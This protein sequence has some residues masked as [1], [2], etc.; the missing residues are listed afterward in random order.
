M[1]DRLLYAVPTAR[2]PRMGFVLSMRGLELGCKT[3]ERS[4][5]DFAYTVGPVQMARSIA[6]GR[7]IDEGYDYLVMHDDD[8]MVSPVGPSGNPLDAWHAL[9]QQEPEVGMIGVAYLGEH[10]ELPLATVVHPDYPAS[11][12][13]PE[14]VCHL[15]AGLRYAPTVVAGV[16][17]GFVMIRVAALKALREAEKAIGGGPPFKF[18]VRRNRFG[19]MV[20]VGEDY[21]FCQRMRATGWKIVI[22]PRFDTTHLKDTGNLTYNW[23]DY[24]AR[25]AGAGLEK[26]LERIG[27]VAQPGCQAIK[28]GEFICLDHTQ[29]RKRDGDAALRAMADAVAASKQEKA[30]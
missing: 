5:Q 13:Q 8:M 17:T 16:G 21:D 30:A 6:V 12:G 25:Y 28:I 24:E 2:H 14:E 22:D 19:A 23:H 4:A 1:A 26:E 29:N 10:A 7:A 18:Q 27:Q 15:I 11:D 20:E 3:F 9:M